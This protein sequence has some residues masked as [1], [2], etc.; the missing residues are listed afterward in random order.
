MSAASLTA[1]VAVFTGVGEHY[2]RKTCA[3][4]A[5]LVTRLAG[6]DND[7]RESELAAD[8][9]LHYLADAATENFKDDQAGRWVM[10]QR[11]SEIDPAALAAELRGG[12]AKYGLVP[13]DE[14]GTRYVRTEWLYSCACAD[15]GY[16]F[17]AVELFAHMERLGWCR[18]GK[19]RRIKATQPGGK[20][21]LYGGPKTLQMS[22]LLV[23]AS[24]EDSQ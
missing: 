23:P 5:G 1:L 19:G 21:G 7:S 18:H 2:D 6:L 10:W 12:Q 11:L 13:V 20:Q 24:W 9:G 15:F 22:F 16:G 4:V 14:R 3:Q 8:I 17:G